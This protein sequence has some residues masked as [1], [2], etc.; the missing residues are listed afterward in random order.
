MRKDLHRVNQETLYQALTT[1]GYIKLNPDQ[2]EWRHSQFHIFLRK[3]GKRGLTLNI[4]E[5]VAS[6]Y[7][8]FH[9]AKHNS[10]ALEQ[11]IQKIIDTYKKLRISPK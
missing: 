5:D 7:P 11:E 8:P 1:L 3:R 9:R 6:P 10:K 2:T 4:H